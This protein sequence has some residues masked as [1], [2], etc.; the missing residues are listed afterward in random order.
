MV[1]K[2]EES[3]DFD[4]MAAVVNMLGGALGGFKIESVDKVKV[5]ANPKNPNVIFVATNLR[6][7]DDE[8]RLGIEDFVT[9]GVE[10]TI[11]AKMFKLN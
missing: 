11:N 8:M 9:E 4:Q 7:K 10:A 6:K 5:V 1:E 2:K 3:Q